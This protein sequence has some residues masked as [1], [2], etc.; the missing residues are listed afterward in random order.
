MYVHNIICHNKIFLKTYGIGHHTHNIL[1]NILRKS[2]IRNFKGLLLLGDLILSFIL[3]YCSVQE[4]KRT[5]F[6]PC[7]QD[8]G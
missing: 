3:T 7:L 2:A 5:F 6:L 8:P 4:I 1:Y